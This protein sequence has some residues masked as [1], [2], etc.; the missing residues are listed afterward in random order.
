MIF[1]LPLREVRE[2]VIFKK[3][4]YEGWAQNVHNLYVQYFRIDANYF[5]S[6]DQE[7][8]EEVYKKEL[9]AAHMTSI[10]KGGGI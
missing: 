2:G 5:D 3:R 9:H 1:N 7:I 6:L 4:Y 10:V 8:R